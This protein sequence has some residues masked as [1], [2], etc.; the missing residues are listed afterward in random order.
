MTN[1][2]KEAYLYAT[3]G[4]PDFPTLLLGL[5]KWGFSTSWDHASA[6]R[7]KALNIKE[8][9]PDKMVLV[10]V[11]ALNHNCAG[12]ARLG[13]EVAEVYDDH[14]GAFRFYE[15]GD[16]SG[17]ASEYECD[18]HCGPLCEGTCGGVCY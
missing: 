9:Y 6:L 12:P 18:H 8:A 1:I 14:I 4:G 2:Q 16:P 7:E 13:F 15:T 3:H 17:A 5:P 10:C 11:G